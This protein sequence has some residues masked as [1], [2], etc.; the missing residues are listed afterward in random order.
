MTQT[1]PWLALIGLGAFHGANPAMGWLFA[2][3][4]GLHRRGEATIALALVPIALGHAV[5]IALAVGLFVLAGHL[6]DARAL[7]VAGGLLLIGWALTLA[8]SGPNCHV[9]L[10]LTTGMLGLF[11]WSFV[12][13]MSHGAGFMLVPALTPL[14]LTD[15]A[16][17]TA[18]LSAPVAAGLTAVALHTA[19]ALAVT[20]AIAVAVYRWIGVAVLR[21]AWINLDWLWIAALLAVGALLLF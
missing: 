9:R 15:P 6:F 4:L 20:G 1:W 8:W 14:C 2:V 5:A 11:L 19:A 7:E 16:A 10:G 17:S 3:A 12:M 18:A 21:T 13:A